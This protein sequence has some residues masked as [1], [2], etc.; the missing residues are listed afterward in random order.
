MNIQQL[1]LQDHRDKRGRLTVLEVGQEVPFSIAR[2]YYL[3]EHQKDYIRG[4]H[5]HKALRQVCIALRGHCQFHLDDGYEQQQ[6]SLTDPN[7]GLLLAPLIWR[8]IR[9]FSADC[10]LM[11]L[12]SEAYVASDYI[13]NYQQFLQTVRQSA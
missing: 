3:F 11:V 1:K 6:I 2:I 13:H 9:D 4:Y 10:L 12:A 5:A 7:Q 8:E